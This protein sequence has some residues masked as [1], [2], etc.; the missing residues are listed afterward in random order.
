MKKIITILVVVLM[1]C[2]HTEKQQQNN[3]I[4][5]M[6]QM[7]SDETLSVDISIEKQSDALIHLCIMRDSKNGVL[8]NI[9]ETRED[10]IG[11]Y[12]MHETRNITSDDAKILLPL[13][14]ERHQSD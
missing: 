6:K 12:S 4:H 1:S 5:T 7:L 13:I 8:L 10:T 9:I 14:K 11:I 3:D 2:A